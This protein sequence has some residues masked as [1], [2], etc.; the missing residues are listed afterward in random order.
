MVLYKVYSQD[1][2]IRYF[3]HPCSS[4]VFFQLCCLLLTFLPPLFTSYFT[5]GFYYKELTYSEQ[6]RISYHGKY[7]IIIG[8]ASSLVFSSSD[9][10]QN[11]YFISNYYPTTLRTAIPRDTDG[12]NIIDQQT[13]ILNVILPQSI[14]DSTVNLWL[15]FQYKLNQYSTISMETL[16]LISLKAPTTLADNATVTIYGQLNFH[17]RDPISNHSDISSISDSIINYGTYSLVPSLNE[18]LNN[19]TSRNYFTTFDQDYVR[20]SSSSTGEPQL[21]LRVVLSTSL[22][23]IRY[24]PSFWKEFRWAWIQYVTALLPFLYLINKVKEFVFSNRLLR[25]IVK[26]SP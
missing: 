24:V 12:D 2:R 19:Y 20:W 11:N 8:S 10:R 15:M 18:I 7:Q 1:H 14:A 9:A 25:T 22:Q 23:S 6:P 3:A 5:S 21:T 4:A 13:I 16:G 17:Q 26:K